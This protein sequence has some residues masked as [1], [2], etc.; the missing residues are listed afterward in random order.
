METSQW[1]ALLLPPVLLLTALRAV[2]P[3]VLYTRASSG[4]LVFASSAV[5]AAVQEANRLSTANQGGSGLA[6]MCAFAAGLVVVGCGVLTAVVGMTLAGF[7]MLMLVLGDVGLRLVLAALSCAGAVVLAVGLAATTAASLLSA[8]AVAVLLL[9]ASAAR[10]L[11]VAAQAAVG[12]VALAVL[13]LAAV[14][15]L[16]AAALPAARQPANAAAVVVAAAEARTRRTLRRLVGR[17]AASAA[18]LC[19][20][21]LPQEVAALASAWP[22]VY[23]PA[24]L[25]G[26]AA[27]L[28]PV[29]D[30]LLV[31]LSVPILA[32][33]GALGG[34]HTA[35]HGL[36]AHRLE[37]WPPAPEVAADVHT[38]ARLRGLFDAVW[39]GVFVTA[40]RIV[41]DRAAYAAA[42]LA[43]ATHVGGQVALGGV[44]E[45]RFRLRVWLLVVQPAWYVLEAGAVAF[46]G[47]L[48]AAVTWPVRRLRPHLAAPGGPLEHVSLS[49]TQI[50][51]HDTVQGWRGGAHFRDLLLLGA[52]GGEGEGVGGQGADEDEAPLA[53]PVGWGA[54]PVGVPDRWPLQHAAAQIDAE[55]PAVAGVGGN[56]E[57]EGE[58]VGTGAA[59]EASLPQR[60]PPPS[61]P[62]S[63]APLR[64]VRGPG[65][66]W[67]A[68]L[69]A[70]GRDERRPTSRWWRL[71]LWPT[72]F[73]AGRREAHVMLQQALELCS[74]LVRAAAARVRGGWG[75]AGDEIV[76]DLPWPEA[77]FVAA[78]DI[79]VPPLEQDDEGQTD[80]AATPGSPTPTP[81]P[82]PPPLYPR[83]TASSLFGSG[84][85]RWGRI[86]RGLSGSGTG[87]GAAD[88]LL[89]QRTASAQ[90]VPVSPPGAPHTVAECAVCGDE[91]AA[92]QLHEGHACCAL[93]LT[94][95][96][97]AALEEGRPMPVACPLCTPDA[98]PGGAVRIAAESLR[99]FLPPVVMQRLLRAEL[100]S[101]GITLVNC[102]AC[103]EAL[104]VPA[105]RLLPIV[106]RAAPPRR[107][108][109]CPARACGQRFCL[110]CERP[111]HDGRPCGGAAAVDAADAATRDFLNRE[112][113]GGR[114]NITRCPCG[115]AIEK[116]DG[117]NHMKHSSGCGLGREGGITHFCA[118]CGG[119]LRRD[120]RTDAEHPNGVHF[121][122]GL[123][124]TCGRAPVARI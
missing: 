103:G 97:S 39:R 20:G 46:A 70:V 80:G 116:V 88:P 31:I 56:E 1:L 11:A 36:R 8:A 26:C 98:Q 54:V 79:D 101:A 124:E 118:V 49:S 18:L 115:E 16:P 29:L 67:C 25:L 30:L 108:V 72:S 35:A 14:L 19:V 105:V 102:P 63:L 27:V 95:H 123:F 23:A 83:R 75:E 53:E 106:G 76:Q 77:L 78:Y 57:G 6:Q 74:L 84:R 12:A 22:H 110:D 73:V 55:A 5:G 42:L 113:G 48:A 58:G 109:R 37:W 114:I 121:P 107:T 89:P 104:E 111:P 21:A 15:L 71:Y 2:A 96:V 24:T 69:L 66:L 50:R 10:L 93:C 40:A 61:A 99:A 41:E 94:A 85:G 68:E 60:P 45:R 120:G 65:E 86:F 3:L 62:P 43:W 119:E 9:L 81:T 51:L 100:R 17:A 87:G 7:S 117:C 44:L 38:Y 32:G 90:H 33:V 13:G 4:A 59:P 34:H 92:A 47:S 28:A 64:P 82:T 52:R 112:R 122:N 91:P